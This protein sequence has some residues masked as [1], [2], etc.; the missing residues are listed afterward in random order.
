MNN[1]MI[2][3][4]PVNLSDYDGFG[5]RLRQLGHECHVMNRA[6]ALRTPRGAD[7]VERFITGGLADPRD[8][9]LVVLTS[10]AWL[11][12]NCKSFAECYD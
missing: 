1:F 10:G 11:P 7:D 9:F 3:I 2:F 12:H 4:D 8:K 5:E 6:W